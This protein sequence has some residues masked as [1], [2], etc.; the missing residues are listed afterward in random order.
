LTPR[1]DKELVCRDE[2][3]NVSRET[4]GFFT[5]AKNVSRETLFFN[6]ITRLCQ[7]SRQL[8]HVPNISTLLR[9]L[10]PRNDKELVYSDE[11]KNVSRETQFL[12]SLRSFAKQSV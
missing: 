3:K 10:T 12:M 6:I 9:R 11:V 7:E 1:N 8:A 5:I 4:F 2:V